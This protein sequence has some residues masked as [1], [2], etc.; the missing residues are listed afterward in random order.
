MSDP[1]IIA[2]AYRHCEQIVCAQDKDHYL[3]SLFAP[4]E[5]R[6]FLFALY[7]FALEIARVRSLVQE[8]LTGT[9][10]LQWWIEALCG[11]RTE[12]AAASPVMIALQDA[13]RQTGVA[14]TPLVGA[15]EARQAELHGEPAIAA[16]SA[17]FAVAA[18]LLGANGD[19]TVVADAAAQAVTFTAEPIKARAGYAA[20]RV[21]AVSLPDNA[22]PAFLTV[23]L[24]PLLL[25]SPDAGQWRRQIALARAAWF[26]FPKL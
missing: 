6:P 23:T 19:V 18:Q 21:L 10:R 13:A 15:I 8:P 11:L 22:L 2:E 17:V 5:R 25:K 4:A 1:G 14:L 26:G 16:V 9:I 12:E 20:F 3:A 7:A 24:V